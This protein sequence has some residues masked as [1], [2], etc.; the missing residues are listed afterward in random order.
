[1][2][3]KV[4]KVIF[5]QMV[6]CVAYLHSRNIC[7]FDVSLEN[8]VISNVMISTL[9]S[10]QFTFCGLDDI[11]VTLIDFGLAE[12]FA[13]DSTFQSTKYCGKTV[14]QSPEITANMKSKRKSFNAKANDIWCLG[15]RF[16]PLLSLS[17]LV[18][19]L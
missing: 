9:D 14:Y 13:K 2:I 18:G 11:R 8:F 5:A 7:H 16:V 12:V 3:R 4:T 15:I 17:V 19:P 1:M 10:D 6:E